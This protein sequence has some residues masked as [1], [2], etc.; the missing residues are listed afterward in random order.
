MLLL[1][2]LP[3]FYHCLHAVW[4][5]KITVHNPKEFPALDL[6]I[7]R[8]QLEYHSG[9]ST[10]SKYHYQGRH[11]ESPITKVRY[12][13]PNK[14]T[15]PLCH[16]CVLLWKIKVRP[17]S[18]RSYL[19]WRPLF[20]GHGFTCFHHP[21]ILP[22]ISFHIKLLSSFLKLLDLESEKTSQFSMYIT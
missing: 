6:V 5:L 4:W 21:D 3:C 18:Y 2:F 7:S 13:P 17:R 1:T 16:H 9:L 20:W 12:W 22:C 15:H 10:H 8:S 11:W 19:L 14:A